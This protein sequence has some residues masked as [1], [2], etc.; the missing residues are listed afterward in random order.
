M[1]EIKKPLDITVKFVGHGTYGGSLVDANEDLAVGLHMF[2][3]QQNLSTEESDCSRKRQF[4]FRF[5][6][7]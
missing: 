2:Y 3:G 7:T 1:R 4:A 6:R 5:S